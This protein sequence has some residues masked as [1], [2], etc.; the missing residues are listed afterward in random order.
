MTLCKQSPY[1]IPLIDEFEQEDNI[2][3]VTKYARGGNLL[4]YLNGRGVT[5]LP[6]Q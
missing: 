6:E 4:N 5:R 3:L 1:I 2:Y